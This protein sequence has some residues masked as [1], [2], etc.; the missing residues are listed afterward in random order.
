MFFLLF[1]KMSEIGAILRL[2]TI[3]SKRNRIV[4]VVEWRG[5]PKKITYQKQRDGH[6]F[7]ASFDDHL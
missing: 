3:I 5:E 4:A 2:K 7:E 1:G 6:C